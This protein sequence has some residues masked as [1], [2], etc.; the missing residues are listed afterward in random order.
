MNDP[1]AQPIHIEDVIEMVFAHEP[2]PP[3][4]Y[5]LALSDRLLQQNVNMFQTLMAILIEGTK[6]VYGSNITPND[7]SDEQFLR[8]R[9]YM[10]SMGYD[11][12][13]SYVYSDSGIPIA[14]NIWFEP[15]IPKESCK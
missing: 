11:I 4:T 15:F 6:R 2:Y 5:N 7:I 9:Y 12:H 3:C 10:Q 1:N 14:V 13:K 8:L